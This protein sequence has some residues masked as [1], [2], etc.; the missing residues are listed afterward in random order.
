MFFLDF[1]LLEIPFIYFRA[2]REIALWLK[3]VVKLC[4]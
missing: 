1:A 2:S 3:M 4:V